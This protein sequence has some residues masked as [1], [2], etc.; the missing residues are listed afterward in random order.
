MRTRLPSSAAI[1]SNNFDVARFAALRADHLDACSAPSDGLGIRVTCNLFGRA[2]D[3]TGCMHGLAPAEP[4]ASAASLSNPELD[5]SQLVTVEPS[6]VSG[7]T[8]I[9]HTTRA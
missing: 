8:K 1:L 4:D 2:H 9:T 3:A 5:L 6:A 7:A